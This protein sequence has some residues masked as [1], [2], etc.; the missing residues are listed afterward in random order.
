M[1]G[2]DVLMRCVGEG[3]ACLPNLCFF[4]YSKVEGGAVFVYV[5]NR[6]KPIM[7]V[8]DI[9]RSCRC[10]KQLGLLGCA[11]PGIEAFPAAVAEDQNV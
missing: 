2:V 11:I 1:F 8:G 3:I 7:L 10:V 9:R 5:L 4:F 6:T